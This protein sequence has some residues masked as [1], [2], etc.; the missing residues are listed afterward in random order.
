M[1][2]PDKARSAGSVP[3]AARDKRAAPV[4]RMEMDLRIKAS[5]LIMA[6]FAFLESREPGINILSVWGLPFISLRKRTIL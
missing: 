6:Y 1:P 3:Q 5:L 4:Q 2:P